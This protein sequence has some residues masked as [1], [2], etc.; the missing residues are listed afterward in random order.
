M[1]HM[2]ESNDNM[3]SVGQTPWH[4]L[5]RVLDNPPTI[6][7][8][9]LAADLN[10]QVATKPLYDAFGEKMPALAT[11]RVDTNETLGV[12]GEKYTPLQ[13][14]EA[15]NFFQPFLDQKQASLETAGSLDGNRKVWVLAKINRDPSVIVQ[16]DEVDKYVLLSNSHDGTLAV[17]VGFTP[18]R[19][20]CNNTLTLA[21]NDKA[22]QLLR[23][24]HVGNVKGAL[25]RIADVMNLA[26]QQF[27]A[28]A[29]QYRLLA[30]KQVNRADIEKYVKLVFA[31]KT[32][33][34]DIAMGKDS[35][36]G[37]R[38]QEHIVRLF[39]SGRGNNMPGVRGTAWALYNAATEYIQYERGSD[40]STRLNQLWFGAGATLNK[41]ALE[42]AVILAAA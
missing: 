12:V 2:I 21:L 30:S 14:L 38:V 41:K 31:T 23:V 18:I 10:W 4:K 34:N 9:I 16:G 25:D 7:D 36:A 22:S 39:E 26:D 37:T 17:R 19:V 13:N 3:F 24:R 35:N 5:G 27:E 8:G 33:L 11:Y 32:Q 29:D 1:A 6:A 42:T 15:F 40:E 28:T 20:V